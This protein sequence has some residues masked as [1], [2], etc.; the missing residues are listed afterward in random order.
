MIVRD[1]DI[2]IFFHD[3]GE[4]AAKTYSPKTLKRYQSTGDHFYSFL[5][6][7]FSS[8]SKLS[9]VT[10]QVIEQYK[11]HLLK[12]TDPREQK[13]KPKTINLT[14]LLLKDILEYA[15]KLGYLNDNP[16]IHTPLL[17]IKVTQRRFLGEEDLRKMLYSMP[18]DISVGI[19]TILNSGITAQELVNLK[20]DNVDLERK[21]M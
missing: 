21:V 18:M 6:T 15:R 5:K 10:P 17:K 7:K 2:D 9:Q 8:L 14:L 20:W 13:L 3:F 19:E 4:Y 12:I 16:A 1:V 11:A